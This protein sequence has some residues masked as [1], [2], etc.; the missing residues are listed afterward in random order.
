MRKYLFIALAC[1]AQILWAGS[2][3]PPANIPSYWSSADGKSGAALWSAVSAQTNVGYSSIGY[4][5]LWTAYATTDVYPGTTKIWDMYGECDFTY[6]NDKC[7]TY[8]GV[9]DC[10]NREHSIPQSWWGGGTSGIG[11]DIFHLVPTDGKING[12]R[13]N[14]EFGE[15]NGG[16]DW[17]GNKSGS[18]GSWSTDKK[19]IASTAGEVING[20]GHVFEPKPQ[21]KGDF[22]RG[23]MGTIIKWQQSNLTTGNSF[24]SGNYTASGYFGLTKKAV[25]LLMKWHREDPVSQKE[26]DRNNGIQKT[27]GNRNP[28]ID[29]P[30]LAE[31]IWGEHAGEA[32]DMSLLMPST[33]PEFVPGV[34]D[35]SRGIVSGPSILSPKKGT[36]EI[37][38]AAPGGSV[39]K[40]ITI[41]G[42]NLE[43]GD[44]TLTISGKNASFFSVSVPAISKAQAEAGYNVTITYAPTAAGSH[45]ANL[46]LNGCGISDYSVTLTGV[47]TS[48]HVVTWKDAVS[49]QQTQVPD[50]GDLF[51][52]AN[53]PADCSED[54][55][56]MGWTAIPNYAGETAPADLFTKASGTVT[57]P[58]TFYA[59][60]ADKQESNRAAKAGSTTT[61]VMEEV[62][63]VSG[64]FSGF[65]FDAQKGTGANPPTYNA[66]GKD[67]RLYAKN[68]LT[69]SSSEA[70]TQIVFNLSQ[71]GLKRLAPITASEGSIAQQA[72]GDETVT[73]TGS[74][75]S[76]TF[77]VGDRAD[78]GSDGS[79][80]AGQLDFSSVDIT[81]GG[82]GAP[83]S[84]SNFSLLCSS[85]PVIKPDYT[86]TFISNGSEHATRVGHAGDQMVIENPAAPCEQYSFKG[87][88]THQYATDNLQYPVLDFTGLIPEG[89]VTY[90]AV[91]MC[92]A[93]QEPSL[94]P[95]DYMKIYSPEELTTGNY[96]VVGENEG[97][98][99]MSA[100]FTGYY[101]RNA[102]VE[103]P[104]NIIYYPADSIIWNIVVNKANGTL[105]FRHA[106][107]GY[108]YIEKSES[109]TKTYYNIKL[110]DN[111]TD[112]K[113][114]YDLDQQTGG[115]IFT[116]VTYPER[117][118][119]Y[120]ASK[121]YWSYYTKQD[122]PVSLYQQQG[123]GEDI[124][125]YTTAPACSPTDIEL[126]QP[127][128]TVT[129]KVLLNGHIYIIRDNKM[130]NLQGIQV[131]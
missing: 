19:T 16:T 22:A 55:V 118:L 88:S 49:V 104:G 83:A 27:Q 82:G 84:Y 10:Y 34:S 38:A 15:V 105:T 127:V 69:I 17:N 44:L 121:S 108:L 74:A 119:E 110:G 107:A 9:C 77:T 59:V 68:T 123:G 116:S 70:M 5:G 24:F 101:L 47:S 20:S 61:I 25:V 126:V 18:A 57:A 39:Y 21:Y 129:R 6:N 95:D 98:F 131:R 109:G 71:Q 76:V 92:M 94:S 28:F 85:E 73:W 50:N 115:W 65:V 13:S 32:V 52:P 35:G 66:G 99:A 64:T 96:V 100:T 58:M 7:G 3:T 45:T 37:G 91:F 23:Y 26:I 48:V 54:R 60:Y 117:Q 125:F 90:Y 4:N 122:A 46:V 43:E 42:E 112:N 102:D 130:Y 12:V 8:S 29:Y 67:A 120:Y 40:D 78:Y 31:Y 80:K 62:Q 128:E 36:I 63:A 30:Y 89:D 79:S 72:S 11:C 53:T 33:D 56:F 124:I 97:L 14:D 1:V 81:V 75:T 41:Q 113:F 111:T 114:T 51:L 106:E 103:A 86:V 93:E 2:V 87:W